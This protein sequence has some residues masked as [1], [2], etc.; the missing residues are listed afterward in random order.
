MSRGAARG[1]ESMAEKCLSCVAGKEE[2]TTGMRHDAG[3][4]NSSL[5]CPQMGAGLI[6][7]MSI[8][9]LQLTVIITGS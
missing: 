7:H 2:V 3:W 8:L 5:L 4:N 9:S 6:P 1:R